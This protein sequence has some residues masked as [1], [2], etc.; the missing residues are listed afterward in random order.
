MKKIG[1]KG[2][3]DF[4][5]G[6]LTVG[7][8]MIA[9]VPNIAK[10][11]PTPKDENEACKKYSF[12]TPP[13]PIPASAIKTRKSAEVVIL[14]AGT[15]GL[16]AAVAA[17]NAGAKVILLEKR[18]T[19][20]S[21]GGWNGT[22]G[23][24]L[25]KSL[26]IEINQGHVM[27]DI[28]HYGAYRANARLIK[29]WQDESGRVMDHLLDMADAAGIKYHID[30][31]VKKFG[32]Y[33]EFPIGVCFEPFGNGTMD[34]MLEKYIRSKGVE[35]LYSTPVVELIR[36]DRKSKVTGV[37]AKGKDGYVQVDATKGVIICTGGYGSNRE[38]LAKYS[39]RSLKAINNQYAEQSNT[40]DGI[41]MGMRIGGAKQDTDCPMLWDGMGSTH[42]IFC[43]LAR[44]P[45]LNVNQL[46]ERYCNEEA[47]F[48]YTANADI[49]QPGSMKW[50]VFD[51]KWNEDKDKFHSSVCKNMQGN[52]FSWNSK[53][54]DSWKGR[55]VI[56]D[57]NTL[58]ELAVKMKVPQ[59]TFIA[60]IKRY[61][62]LY[63]K[64][65]DEDYGKDSEHLTSIVQPPFGAAHTGSGILVTL[66][67]LRINTN[68]QVL[69]TEGNPIDGLYAAGNASG[70]FFAHDYPITCIGSSCG[71][72]GTFGWLAGEKVAGLS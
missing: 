25:H 33:E 53:S 63:N 18:E 72:A 5:K 43:S 60:T 51:G 37:I 13:A 54:Y 44:Q 69:D 71:R 57:A 47:P 6:S 65:V 39:P 48:G 35:V 40:G 68:L 8:A 41:L 3:R 49:Q 24:R 62:E 70:D 42:G 15:S 50:T 17:V 16:R 27:A 31:K 21:H 56:V 9:G 32:I 12:D 61:N 11:A 19:F 26:G 45:F 66:D 64:G 29:L 59:D 2:R 4:L 34:P 1:T 14:G 58:E 10:G 22:I 38:M 67:G 36:K 52:T 23:D 46:G 7:A 28:M 30:T 55:G 20:T